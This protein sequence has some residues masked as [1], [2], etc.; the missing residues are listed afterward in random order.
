MKLNIK[1]ITKRIAYVFFI[2]IMVTN[3][4]ASYAQSK[5]I[6][7]SG[8][9]SI[10]TIFKEIEKQAK[11]SVDYDLSI[12]DSKKEINI[13]VREKDLE[14]VLKEV[15][16]NTGCTYVIKGTHIIIKKE[17]KNSDTKIVTGSVTDEKNQTL[18]MVNVMVKGTTTGVLTST[19]GTY[20]ITI[21]ENVHNPVLVYTFIG[22]QDKEEQINARSVLNVTL[23]E[24]ISKLEE[25]IVIGYSTVK[26][27][28]IT[29][30]VS[31]VSTKDI[32]ERPLVS[33]AQAIAGR[34]AG[35]QVTQ[36][37]G[38]PGAGLSVR[39]RGSTSVNADN[40]PLYVV[41]GIPSGD[42]AN[43]NPNDIE[44]MQI[45]KD[46]S[47][48]AIYGARAANGV[49]LITTKRG[50]AGQMSI[51][52]NAYGGVSELG[53]KLDA[54]NTQQ[55]KDLMS[56][57]RTKDNTIPFIPESE[58]RYTD[59]TDEFFRT[60]VNQ[61]YQLSVSNGSDKVQ[62]FMSAGYMKETGIV[63]K[64]DFRRYSFRAN[65]DNKLTKW[66]T[67]ALNV[68][69]SNSGGSQVY[70]N[71][72]AFR[73]GS[74]LSVINTPPFMQVW[75]PSNPREYDEYAYGA[76]IL[77]PIAANAADR[78]NSAD[79]LIGLLN[80]TADIFSGLKYKTNFG[81][82]LTNSKDNYYLDPISSS[83]GRGTKGAVK[84]GYSR[85]FEWIFEN[86]LTYDK[87]I[88]KHNI[89]LLG[90][91]I[92]QNAKYEGANISGFDLNSNYP[93]IR[94]INA[95]NQINLDD[96]WSEASEWSLA[97]FIGKVSYNYQSKYLLTANIRADGSSRFAPGKKWGYFPSLSAGWR[98]SGEEF[99][100]N[101]RVIN[102]LK[103]RA[104]WGLTGNQSGIGNYDYLA[105]YYARKVAP[106]DKN[107]LPGIS[108]FPSTAANKDLTWE[109]T[110]QTNIGLDLTILNSR[111][112]FT[113]DA[114]YKH[115]TDL[116]LKLPL[117]DN[118]NFPDG[119]TRNDGEME[120]KGLEFAVSTKNLNGKLS[121]TTDFNIS[122]N[123]NKVTKLGFSK[124]YYYA[125][126]YES[127]ENAVILKEGMPLG[128]FFGYRSLGVD[129]ETGDLMYADL[130]KNGIKDPGDR[131]VIGNAQ[132]TFIYGMTNSVSFA[133][134]D[135]SVLIQG[136][137]GNKIFNASK[138]D[139]EG[140]KDFRNQSVNVLNRWKRPGMITD[141][142]RS[143]NIENN[144]N[145][146]R[147]VEDGSYMRVKNITLS[148]NF[149]PK[150]LNKLHISR[151][152]PYITLQ[153]LLT[154]TNYSGYDPEV[155]AFDGN[156]VALGVDY[157]TY[158]QS[159]IFIIGL[160]IEF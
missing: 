6:T 50:K 159:K 56:E 136:S 60:G 44:S 49:V 30:A 33:A 40:E 43:I 22:Y 90:G 95:A 35:V 120:N 3:S 106:S 148:Y 98:I 143:G 101:I 57:M 122:M 78:N 9:Q 88:G 118:A 85:N 111:V 18:P 89:S 75:D 28:D 17:E 4:F 132:P 140:M 72:S 135:L 108:L 107:L 47:S 52:F 76:R 11:M 5:K 97:S 1:A 16:V 8:K 153:N 134:F 112:V 37:S 34:S 139:M 26:K 92:I 82:D 74:I 15:M 20:S 80:F 158:P 81:I 123:K 71:R 67:S 141:V 105:H 117:G 31:I 21:P 144:S 137:Q 12:I 42:I 91:S 45:L 70:E 59:W 149:N 126:M 125:E 2:L 154:I 138:I 73:A 103:I 55:Y 68:S 156:A 66:L 133:G 13:D 127:K 53:K 109:K 94:T 110:T 104:G 64:A 19:D 147:F 128:N 84:E 69:Y 119:I 51:K 36:N 113:A 61:S 100:R 152:Q 10:Q 93:N 48:A 46:A 86:M 145:S 62:Y 24:D 114:Y 32:E 99:M 151:L 23:S 150:L 87:S 116:L 129:P 27:K 131:E 29:T 79:R 115:T 160:N 96:T 124:V 58:N 142:P 54:L 157:G 14:S 102:D 65:V 25:A 83:D 146:S 41:D 63:D 7:L 77:N 130:N 121:W 155:N 38:R 39:V